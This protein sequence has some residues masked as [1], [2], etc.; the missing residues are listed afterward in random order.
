MGEEEHLAVARRLSELTDRLY[1]D[2]DDVAAAEMQ[3]GAV[4]RIIAAIA[5]Q[6]GLAAPGQQPRRGQVIHHLI[7]NHIADRQAAMGLRDGLSAPS[8]LHGH[9]YNS[10]LDADGV[11]GRVADTRTF[12]AEL[13]NL[14]QQHGR[15]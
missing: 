6:H 12:I 4:N 5:L 14:H 3:W 10:H 2:G 11:A 9:F 1:R 13:L 8:E 7:S 15:R